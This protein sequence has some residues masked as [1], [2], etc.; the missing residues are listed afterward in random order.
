[1]KK[2]KLQATKPIRVFIDKNYSGFGNI[3]E[4]KR[5]NLS[6]KGC[7]YT[8]QP[9]EVFYFTDSNDYDKSWFELENGVVFLIEC[10]NPKSFTDRELVNIIND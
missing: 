7:Y 6:W 2:V 10:G 8:I 4:H 9:N 1:M 5:E 3:P